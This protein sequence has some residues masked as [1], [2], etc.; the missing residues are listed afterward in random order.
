MQL[1]R[2]TTRL[3]GAALGMVALGATAI[4]QDMPGEGVTVR[5]AASTIAEESFQAELMARGPKE[6]GYDMGPASEL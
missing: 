4:A 2:L 1:E 6:L 5:P 3:A